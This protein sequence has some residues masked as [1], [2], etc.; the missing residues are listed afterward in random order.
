MGQ[1]KKQM[2]DMTP[3]DDEIKKIEAIIRSMTLEERDSP[4]ILNGSRRERIA[5]GSG[6]RVQDIN[7][8]M[9]QFEQAKKMITQMMKMGMGKG[10]FPGMGGGKGGFPGMGGKGKFPF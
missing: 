2:K 10:G 6:T 9:K 5:K 3:P 7:R 1:I 8:F 4:D